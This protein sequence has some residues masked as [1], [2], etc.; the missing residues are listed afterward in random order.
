MNLH[1]RI[2]GG[3]VGISTVLALVAAPAS[4]FAATDTGSTTATAAT[5]TATVATTTTTCTDGHWPSSVQGRPT[6][7]HAGAS[8][9]DYIWH[10]STGWHVRVTHPG[11]GRVVFTGT[12][13]ASAP[14][15]AVPVKLEKNDV[16]T[17]SA[18][19]RTITYRLVNYGAIDGFDFRASCASRISF[20][21]RA[22]GVRLATWRI[23]LG[24]FDRHPLENPFVVSRVG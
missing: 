18:D 9:G 14:L 10:D 1:R 8:A 13:V 22:D 7:F 19:K 2:V 3:L 11:K 24:H 23:R 17:V 6:E 21:G 15:D 12:I 20:G 5:T 4:T 16:V